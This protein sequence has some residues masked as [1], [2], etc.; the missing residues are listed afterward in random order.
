MK[1]FK[2]NG[3][4]VDFVLSKI[5]AAVEKANK[6]T[7][8][9][10]AKEIG[11]DSY[12]E[13]FNSEDK[14]VIK[15]ASKFM[16]IKNTLPKVI[17]T[18]QKFLKPF[19]TVSV[20]D[21][22]DLVEK[23]L[24]KNNAYEVAKEYILYRDNKK[25]EKK[26]TDTEETVLSILDGSNAEA[27]GDNANKHI[28][29]NS[30]A[31]DYIAGTVCKSIAD[32]MLPKEIAKAH[33]DGYIHWHDKDYSPVM[34]MT[35]CCLLNTEDML[36][37][38]FQM[39]DIH[40]DK[41]K[42]VSTSGNLLSQ[43]SLI[44]S[45]QQYGGQTSTISCL[46]PIVKTTR[47][48][49]AADYASELTGKDYKA[50]S[51]KESVR[52]IYE[53]YKKSIPL[54]KRISFKKFTDVVEKKTKH[55]IHVGI[56]TYAWQILCHH[57]SNGQS[58]FT[59]LVL[60]LRE[61][62]NE[63]ELKDLAF[64]IEEVLQR[65]IKGVTGSHGETITPLFPKLLYW[66]CDGLNV[67]PSDPYYYLTQLAAKCITV[68][69]AP[70]INSEKM[71]R[72]IK[73]GQM[74]PS[75][76]AARGDETVSIR[77]GEKEY[78]NI[79]IKEAFDKINA[80]PDFDGK[81]DYS[82]FSCF[83]GKKGAY[84][85]KLPNGNFFESTTKD[86]GRQLADSKYLL[87][88]FNF[89]TSKYNDEE[90]EH[91]ESYTWFKKINRPDVLILSKG[92]WENI[93]AITKN[94]ENSTLK[95]FEVSYDK[96]GEV[97]TLH[98]TEDHPLH[99]QKGRVR[100]DELEIGDEIYDSKTFEPY[101]IC[102]I[103]ITND[104]SETYDFE[105][106]NDMFDLSGIISHNCRSW[107]TPLWIE[108]TYPRNTKFHW[109]RVTDKS[110]QYPDAPGKNFDFSKGFGEYSCLPLVKSPDEKIAIN[111][112][113]NTGW[114]KEE[115]DKTVTIIE[116]KVYGRWNNGVV[117]INIPM[118]AGEAREKVNKLHNVN[119]T[120]FIEEYS[121]EYI[122]QFYKDFSQGL[123]LCHKALLIRDDYCKKIRAKNSPLLWM[124]GGFLREKDPEKT[125]GEMMA[126]HPLYNTISLG[127]VGLF[128][129]C[130]ALLNTS[131]TTKKGQELST[132]ILEYMNN[133]VES[134]KEDARK[135]K[136][137]ELENKEF[138][139]DEAV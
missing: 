15:K 120:E 104:K 52:E 105:V 54:F 123:E 98:I 111:F 112:R 103:K 30:S 88:D 59:S 125:L 97:R 70:D 41:P 29:L 79:S 6:S 28:D 136:I 87:G 122:Q 13:A 4:E 63:Q 40:I 22:S 65:R 118:Y 85:I 10:Y 80:L 119:P 86:L 115:N 2:K 82:E 71:S 34:N 93:W 18:T 134:W 24:M 132:S 128:E 55:D 26:F 107:L 27:R 124:Y 3:K 35:N 57:S 68:R 92:K 110:I 48:A 21:I 25:K 91:L 113:G 69:M 83:N 8:K 39:G 14:E 66:T 36:L 73:S 84:K 74:I 81:I 16:L 31:R 96:N 102:G 58:P 23:S 38:G 60:N 101:K 32:K 121:S 12:E 78:I 9:K 106:S 108:K 64:L 130:E 139:L 43:I 114:L 46:L 135:E 33:K 77:I 67:N 51:D 94:D 37:N 45:G 72:Q 62:E 1:V 138:S 99:T 56:K 11:V 90:D 53:S 20:E 116:P 76:G 131:N 133:T 126:E 137:V 129:T 49:C 47:I 61:A 44:T 19:D 75:M 127:Y 17:E 109:Q 5:E 7:Y 95:M 42:R 50:F 117:T 100:A 89:E